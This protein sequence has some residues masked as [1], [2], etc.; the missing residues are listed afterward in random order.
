MNSL[1]VSSRVRLIAGV[2]FESTHVNTTSFNSNTGQ[3]D[4]TAGGDYTDVLPSASVKF[5][6]TPNTSVRVVQPRAVTARSPDISQ[7]VGP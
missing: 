3:K 1:D 6:T 4:F 2:R 7:A 5:S